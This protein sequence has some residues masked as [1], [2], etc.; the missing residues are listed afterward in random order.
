LILVN[1][2]NAYEWLFG[3]KIGE[4][5]YDCNLRIYLNFLP[6][7]LSRAP[8]SGKSSSSVADLKKFEFY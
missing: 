4:K 2:G 7:S 5:M 6:P 1:T 3:K 8:V